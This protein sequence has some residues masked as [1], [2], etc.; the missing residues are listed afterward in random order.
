MI[1][2]WKSGEAYEGYIG[3]WSRLVAKSFLAWLEPPH[4]LSWLDVGCGPG[5]LS[6]TILGFEPRQ[7]AGIDRSIA[8]VQEARSRLAD[9]RVRFVVGDAERLPAKGAYFDRVVSGLVLNFV[10]RP[11]IALVEMAR[12]T[13]PSG[14][15][16]IYLWD[17]A[18]GME[19]LRHFWDAATA[20][21]P[22]A[23]DLD[24]GRRFPICGPEPLT[25]LLEDAGLERIESR[26]I[27]VPTRFM[28]FDDYWS[29][30]LGGQGPAPGYAMSLSDDRR[31]GLRDRIRERLPV[32][33]DGS[34]TLTARAWAIRGRKPD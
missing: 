19:L 28:S 24:E 25:A 27:D 10:P 22:A 17:Y 6:A 1:D 26:P 16:A 20:L 33:A 7:V 4:A 30:F 29:P 31:A 18:G 2:G 14:T 13:R 15:I 21:D 12:A 9:P 5:A 8:Y 11:E 3:R 32:D 23:L 34:I